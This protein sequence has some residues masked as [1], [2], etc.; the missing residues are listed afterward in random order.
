MVLMA[1]RYG[2]FYL[3]EL[4]GGV[5]SIDGGGIEAESPGISTVSDGI[6]EIKRPAG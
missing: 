5:E 3:N 1:D 2:H 6:A 4:R